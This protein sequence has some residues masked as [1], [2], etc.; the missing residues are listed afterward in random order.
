MCVFI[1]ALVSTHT[2]H[3]LLSLFLCDN[4]SLGM[5]LLVVY[6][7]LFLVG[8]YSSHHYSVSYCRGQVLPE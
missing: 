5:C 3:V 1:V 4:Y 7:F 8:L 2:I 6:M